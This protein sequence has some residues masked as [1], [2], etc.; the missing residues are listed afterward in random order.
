MRV[1]ENCA[2]SQKKNSGPV[3][4]RHFQASAFGGEMRL[5]FFRGPFFTERASVSRVPGSACV[6]ISA[7]LD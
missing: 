4:R 7:E 1:A 3:F 6:L 5:L 2:D